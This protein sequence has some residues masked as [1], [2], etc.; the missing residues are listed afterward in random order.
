MYVLVD[1]RPYPAFY[2]SASSNAR[3]TDNREP[4]D[5]KTEY[6]GFERGI[7]VSEIGSG[8]H[9]LSAIAVTDTGESYLGSNGEERRMRFKL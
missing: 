2:G 1:G 4:G 8:E 6:A 9:E 5:R 3:R 7:P